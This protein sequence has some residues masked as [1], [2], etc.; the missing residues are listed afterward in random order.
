[1][2]PVRLPSLLAAMSLVTSSGCGVDT[3]RK[4]GV[5]APANQ[6]DDKARGD[7]LGL[8]AVFLVGCGP[9]AAAS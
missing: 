3:L 1:M 8:N 9:T 2:P 6:G 5:K 4:L 7:I